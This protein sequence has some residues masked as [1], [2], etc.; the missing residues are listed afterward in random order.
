MRSGRI[1]GVNVSAGRGTTKVNVGSG[2]LVADYGLSGDAHAGTDRQVSVFTAEKAKELACRL[3]IDVQP[4]DFAEN[5][6]VA[7]I[8]FSEVV[9]GARLFLGEAVVEVTG[10]GKRK[11]ETH[12]FS[13]HGLAPLMTEGLYCRVVTGGPDREGDRAGFLRDC[14][15]LTK[16]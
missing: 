12:T 5:I 14:S 3:G 16:W 8:D 15:D 7:G 4:G 13:F 11:G 10:I 9:P 2:S 6:T 1:V